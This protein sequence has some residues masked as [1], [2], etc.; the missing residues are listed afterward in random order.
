MEVQNLKSYIANVGMT[1]T[2]F[3]KILDCHPRYLARISTG[4][5][6]PGKR[7]ARDLF[8]ATNGVIN[9]PTKPRKSKEKAS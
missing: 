1:I 6:T 7:L 3:S 9:L 8:N 5:L 4:E 2:E